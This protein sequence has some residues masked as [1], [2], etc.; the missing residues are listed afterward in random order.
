MRF[1]GEGTCI[2]FKAKRGMVLKKHSLISGSSSTKIY[3]RR[4]PSSTVAVVIIA[5]AMFVE[6]NQLF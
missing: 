6:I 5:E 3:S 1:P 4:S 2:S